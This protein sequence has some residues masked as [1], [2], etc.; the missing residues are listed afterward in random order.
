MDQCSVCGKKADVNTVQHVATGCM[1]DVW[2]C[3]EDWLV[4]HRILCAKCAEVEG[5]R[6]LIS[7]ASKMLS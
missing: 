2:E 7:F 6:L 5:E 3:E 1:G 4:S